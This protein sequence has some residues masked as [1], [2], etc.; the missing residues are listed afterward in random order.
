[1]KIS[2]T[3]LVA[4][5]LYYLQQNHF[6]RDNQFLD[7][8]YFETSTSSPYQIRRIEELN[9]VRVKLLRAF[10]SNKKKQKKKKMIRIILFISASYWPV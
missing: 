9:K 1:M 6:M 8:V 5:D 2:D 7:Y 10:Y 3:A 4:Y